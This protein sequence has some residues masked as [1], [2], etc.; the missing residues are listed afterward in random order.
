MSLPRSAT[1]GGRLCEL[2]A[3]TCLPRDAADIVSDHH[4][5]GC[6]SPLR[7]AKRDILLSRSHSCALIS[8]PQSG[9]TRCPNSLSG[10]GMNKPRRAGPR[11]QG[12]S[13][14]S[15]HPSLSSRASFSH[16]CHPANP[17]NPGQGTNRSVGSSHAIG[18]AVANVAAAAAAAA[19]HASS[20]GASQR[21]QQVLAR[22]CLMYSG[23]QGKAGKEGRE[24][25]QEAGSS[26][27][28]SGLS[29]TACSSA[30][31]R[32]AVAKEVLA[33]GAREA[34]HSHC[35]K[36]SSSDTHPPA[37]TT[38]GLAPVLSLCPGLRGSRGSSRGSGSGQGAQPPAT[39]LNLYPGGVGP[40][41]VVASLRLDSRSPC[42]PASPLLPA[43]CPTAPSS[44]SL[45]ALLP[46]PDRAAPPPVRLSLGLKLKEAVGEAAGKL[47]HGWEEAEEKLGA[48]WG[49]AGGQL[50]TPLGSAEGGAQPGRVIS[51]VQVGLEPPGA[52]W[53]CPASPWGRLSASRGRG[54]WE[55]L[56]HPGS[57]LE[58]CGR[59]SGGGAAALV[60]RTAA[61]RPAP[62]MP[63]EP[64]PALS[65][66]HVLLTSTSL[67]CRTTPV[68]Q[69]AVI[70]DMSKGV[71][72]AGEEVGQL[73]GGR[74]QA[75]M[76]VGEA[77]AGGRGSAC[78]EC[79]GV[80]VDVSEVVLRGQGSTLGDSGPS[81]P[82]LPGAGSGPGS[83]LQSALLPLPAATTTPGAGVTPMQASRAEEV[84]QCPGA[85]ARQA[86]GER[87]VA[88]R[89]PTMLQ[90]LVSRVRSRR[91]GEAV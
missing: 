17:A 20:Y 32:Q 47:G 13:L 82:C 45:P 70:R 55:V 68:L 49:A 84:E 34:S 19:A 57:L 40:R 9:N 21:L 39:A 24:G 11:A 91:S 77:R 31:G 37:T 35:L 75:R 18:E 80:A 22:S 41:D 48:S 54:G 88:G 16:T 53:S 10:A 61:T 15:P 69:P 87:A 51:G 83:M 1:V 73:G 78:F 85:G 86:G 29:L 72:G 27:S 43:S 33:A 8:P 5:P 62:V 89:P 4:L 56:D 90:R 30:C 63:S 81:H 44:P 76:A 65:A 67:H 3:E 64:L 28:R 6:V 66:P 23:R 74:L 59:S 58:H 79:G 46:S 38:P 52:A 7:G 25:V 14:D 60:A 71:G 12:V 50:D 42:L 26:H 2:E 36:R